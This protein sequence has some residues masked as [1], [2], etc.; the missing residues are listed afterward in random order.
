LLYKCAEM[1]I[2]RGFSSFVTFSILMLAGSV[3]FF[4]SAMKDKKENK[5]A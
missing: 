4:I 1:L 3:M 5:T 2:Q